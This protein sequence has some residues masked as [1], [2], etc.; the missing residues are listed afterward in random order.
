MLYPFNYG[1][2]AGWQPKLPRHYTF[3]YPQNKR[4]AAR[5]LNTS[6]VSAE[7]SSPNRRRSRFFP[8]VAPFFLLLTRRPFLGAQ[9]VADLRMAYQRKD[10]GAADDVARQRR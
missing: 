6:P 5:L 7:I 1:D 9:I 8:A 2:A 10:K 3:F 4:L